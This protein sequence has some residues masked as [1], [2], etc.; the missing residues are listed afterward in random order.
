MKTF[1][2]ASALMFATCGPTP[3]KANVAQQRKT[4]FFKV[5]VYENAPTEGIGAVSFILFEDEAENC[6]IT[7][8]VDGGVA[9]APLSACRKA[10]ELQVETIEKLEQ[11]P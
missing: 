9:V 11:M 5:L 7:S 3:T 4:P 6:Y 1:I 8:G 2:I 10:K